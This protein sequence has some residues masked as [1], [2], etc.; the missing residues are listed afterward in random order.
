MLIATNPFNEQVIEEYISL[1]GEAIQDSIAEVRAA[2]EDWSSRTYAQRGEVLRAVAA[3]LR[4]QKDHLAKLMAD[5]MGKPIKEGGP[6]VEKAAWC[7][8]Y[9]AEHAEAF[10]QT[11]VIESDASKSYVCYP[12]LGT[13]LGVLPWNAPLWLA[14]RY[15]APGL[16]AGNTCVLKHD[17]NVPACG[18][19]IEQ[20][21]RDAGAPDNIMRNLPV[22]TPEVELAIRDPNIA[23]VSFTGSAVGGAKVAAMAAS[24]I[25]PAVLELGGSDPCIVMAD[26]DLE[27][28]AD[29]ATLSRIINAGQSCI[30]AKR[31]LVE[32]IVYDDFVAMLK[33][34]LAKLKMGD[35]NDMETDIGPIARKDLQQNLHR[36]VQATVDAGARCLLGGELPDGPGFFYPPTLLVDVKPE[37]CA[38]REETF[39][40]VMVVTP[41]ADIDEAVAL[42]NDTEYGLGAGLWMGDTSKAEQIAARIEAGQVAVNGIVKTDPRLPSGG[43]KRS[44]YGRELGP[45]GIK[46][47]VNAKQVW[48]K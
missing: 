48:I 14:F 41:V 27:K 11:E 20:I 28:A 44:G 12:P 16:M 26:A 23:A 38:F 6:E 36:Q 25:K 21:F 35:P 46:E 8:E 18:I 40:P 33:E 32:Q 30:A 37:M 10:L 47:F 5:E 15:L 1:N 24:E 29:V 22:K 3:E 42:A 4:K 31:I 13:L 43:I 17:P 7:A 39:G 45:H 2:F 34:R 9:Y 19:A